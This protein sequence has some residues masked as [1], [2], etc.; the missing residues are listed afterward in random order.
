MTSAQA[1]ALNSFP[2]YS[3]A[4]SLCQLQEYPKVARQRTHRL[5][6]IVVFGTK[7]CA[8]SADTSTIE[9]LENAR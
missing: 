6:R 8:C 4:V 2:S 9:W 7:A 3:S 5:L 1:S